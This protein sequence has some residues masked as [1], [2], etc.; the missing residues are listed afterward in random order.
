MQLW[1]AFHETVQGN[2]GLNCRSIRAPCSIKDMLPL[3]D[4]NLPYNHYNLVLLIPKFIFHRI[5][6]ESQWKQCKL[7]FW[8]IKMA[9]FVYR[10]LMPFYLFQ[11]YPHPTKISVSLNKKRTS[12]KKLCQRYFNSTCTTRV[13]SLKMDKIISRGGGKRV[14]PSGQICLRES[15]TSLHLVTKHGGVPLHPAEQPLIWTR[16]V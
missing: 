2:P 10:C 12:V 5:N 3:N 13:A 11:Y 1:Y 6:N 14:Q 4:Y 16:R 7:N 9:R 15:E 8:R